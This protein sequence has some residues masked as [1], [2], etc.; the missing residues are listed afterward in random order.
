M[1]E[2]VR[3]AIMS[4]IHANARAF[5]AALSGLR[6]RG[7]DHLVIL[8]DLLTYGAEP[9]E[10]LEIA[11]REAA[12]GA[13]F[14]KGN[15]DQLYF[16][17]ATGKEDYLARLPDWLQ[18]T[19]RWTVA[20][21]GD[22]AIETRF[23]WRNDWIL[24]PLFLAHANPFAYGDWSYLNQNA[25]FLRAGTALRERGVRLGI[26]GHTHR[27]KVV[28]LPEASESPRVID[29]ADDETACGIPQ[30]GVAIFD[31]GSTGQPRNR[32]KRATA[33]LVTV[34]KDQ[35]SCVALHLDYDVA[36]HRRTVMSTGMSQSTV[37]KLLGYFP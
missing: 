13:I 11:A 1:S 23:P 35:I 6:D 22:A 12:A 33:G 19:A 32:Q 18:E 26:F 10:V 9:L 2:Q 17:L 28:L 5:E 31:V 16:D 15:H 37:E 36:A 14:I 24:G 8:G 34:A 21:I 4:D 20:Q 25:D 29:L 27:P 7:F 3:I 30:A